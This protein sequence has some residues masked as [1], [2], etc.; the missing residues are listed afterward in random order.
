MYGQGSS[1]TAF[2]TARFLTIGLLLGCLGVM[3]CEIRPKPFLHVVEYGSISSCREGAAHCSWDR[4]ERDAELSALVNCL[5]AGANVLEIKEER[6]Q[7]RSM[8]RRVVSP[9]P[10]RFGYERGSTSDLDSS[11]CSEANGPCFVASRHDR[12]VT[13][14]SCGT[15]VLDEDELRGGADL[16]RADG[17]DHT[18]VVTGSL[19]NATDDHSGPTRLDGPDH[20]YRVT[21]TQQTRIEAAV[22]ANRALW[23]GVVGLVQSPWQPA[24]FLLSPD[25]SQLQQGYV[26][27]AGVTALLP[28]EVKPGTYY[29]VVDSSRLEWKRGD[30]LYRLY[31]G[32]NRHLMGSPNNRGSSRK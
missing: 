23:S 4:L 27:R 31:V 30:G 32:L 21:V 28:A 2:F 7:S 14:A 12:P 16:H 17:L 19:S 20:W 6:G 18:D 3:G 15:R 24:L 29:L 25:G 13:W 10:P 1:S 26:F 5:L 11:G 9:V 8:L 22:A